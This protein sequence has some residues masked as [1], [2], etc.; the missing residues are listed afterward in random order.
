MYLQRFN[1]TADELP[2]LQLDFVGGEVAHY[3]LEA[4]VLFAL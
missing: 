2:R 1:V 3:E 4:L